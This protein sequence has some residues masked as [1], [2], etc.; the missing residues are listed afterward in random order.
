MV[1]NDEKF[2]VSITGIEDLITISGTMSTAS[3][4]IEDEAVLSVSA[5]ADV[6]ELATGMSVAR[7]TVS[8]ADGVTAVSDIPFHGV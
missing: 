3:V 6:E 4:T 7:F 2:T 5:P 8:L 1:E